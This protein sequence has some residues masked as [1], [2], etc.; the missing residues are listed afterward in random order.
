[1]WRDGLQFESPIAIAIK[2]LR[3]EHGPMGELRNATFGT[4]K[5]TFGGLS[6]TFLLQG[7]IFNSPFDQDLLR[8]RA[9]K[10]KHFW[11]VI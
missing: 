3:L 2:S 4:Q 9:L 5:W 6:E 7:W 1:M 8:K 10:H 11:R